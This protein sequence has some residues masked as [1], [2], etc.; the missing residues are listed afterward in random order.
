MVEQGAGIKS[1]CM[2]S[3]LRGI[4]DHLEVHEAGTQVRGT[5]VTKDPEELLRPCRSCP[6]SHLFDRPCKVGNICLIDLLAFL[7]GR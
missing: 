4:R 1:L 7:T 5:R 6:D 3:I 2:A